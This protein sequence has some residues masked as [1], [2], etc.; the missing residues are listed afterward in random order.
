MPTHA[1]LTTRARWEQ[2]LETGVLEMSSSAEPGTFT[3]AYTVRPKEVRPWLEAA[4]FETLDLLACEGL[5]GQVEEGIKQLTDEAREA[6]I[7]LGSSWALA[8]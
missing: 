5:V 6:W 2:E 7:D 3:E 1:I 8:N 4:G